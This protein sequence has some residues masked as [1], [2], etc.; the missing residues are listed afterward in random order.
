MEKELERLKNLDIIEKVTGP[1]PWVS[2]IVVVPKSSGQV[3]LCM[4]MREANKAVTRERHLMPTIDDLVADLN[5]ATVFSKL[6]FSSGY[7]QLKLK[8]ESCHITTFSTHKGFEEVQTSDVRN[9][10][11]IRDLPESRKY[12]QAYRDARISL[13]T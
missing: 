11:S 10:R 5:G 3:R 7:H 6:D 2:P 4:D 12:L 9:T 8:P 1:T 13:T